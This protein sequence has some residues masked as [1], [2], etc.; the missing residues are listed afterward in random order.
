MRVVNMMHLMTLAALSGCATAGNPDPLE[1]VNRKTFAFNQKLDDIVLKPVAKGYQKVV[2]GSVR[3]S[4]RNFYANPRDLLS[5]I[6]SFLQGRQIDGTSDLM[7]FA[8]NST[9]GVLG[10]FDVATPL[11][12]EKHNED[13]GQAL[14]YWGLGSGAY[15]V[16]PVFG[17]SSVR[18]TTTL[19]SN[20][21]VTPQA[22][23]SDNSLYYSLTALQIT[24]ARSDQLTTSEILDDIS[25]DQ[26]L[27]VRDAYL[28]YRE[29]LVHNG[30][31]PADPDFE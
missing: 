3:Q 18:D 6:S 11:G 23:V 28:R 29:S 20:L 12:F 4:V 10:L 25:I 31:L 27:F 30:N 15:I 14:G 22:L 24:N 9:I 26:Y 7:R 5:A 21:A 8:T 1:Q 17:P 2:P 13:L 19:V 16:W